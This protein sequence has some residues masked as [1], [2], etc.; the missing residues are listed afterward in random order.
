MVFVFSLSVSPVFATLSEDEVEYEKISSGVNKTNEKID[1][2]IDKAVE[3][4]EEKNKIDKIDKIKEKLIDGTNKKAA[5]MKKRAANKGIVVECD[6]VD[7]EIGG[8]IIKIDPL[9]I[10]GY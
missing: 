7:V 3:D 8:E 4:A 5:N 1:K 10:A 2:M 9:R 6:W